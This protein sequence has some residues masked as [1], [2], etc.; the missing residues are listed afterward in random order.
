MGPI[1]YTV[2]VAD[3]FKA[4]L[5]GYTGGA[6]IRNDFQAQD[7]RRIAIQ[8][9]QQQQEAKLAMQQ[10]LYR[11]STNKAAT[12]ADYASTMT[13][14]PQ[15]SEQLKKSWDVLNDDQKQSKLSQGSQAYAAIKSGRPD[16]AEK[17]F[18]DRAAA[19]KNTGDERAAKEAETM[20]E[21]IR[22]HP[23]SA[24][25]SVALSLAA[26]MGPEKF[27]SSFASLGA[28]QR[29]EAEAPAD[30]AIKNATAGIKGAEAVNTP[31]KL[32]LDN[33][34]TQSQI[35]DRAA[36]QRI[37]ELNTQIGQANSETQRGQLILERDK[38]V[39]DQ[40]FKKADRGAKKADEGAA[41]QDALDSAEALV[42]Q[43]K[44]VQGHPGL[45]AGTGTMSGIRSF[46]NSTD[47][48]DFRKAVEGLKSP[49]FLNELGKLKA[50]GITLGQV[51]EAEGKKLEQRIANLDP[52][53]ST[54][55]FKNQVGVLLKDTEKFIEKI[56]AGGKLPI[57]GGAFLM[58]VPG[59]GDV[60]EGDINRMLTANPGST[61]EQAIQYL[62]SRAA[63][64]TGGAQGS[65]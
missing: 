41:A 4:A 57:S 47:A 39:A 45:N 11:L 59:V 30:L 44:G 1:D 33:A 48:N 36:G 64:N 24:G 52:D 26:Y 50:A 9:A 21:F 63:K 13:R 32:A 58:K 2:Q 53:Q 6:A 54:P 25:T 20:A 7:D 15:F 23:E 19:A 49:V 18:R 46:F 12:G 5:Q 65:Y 60:R 42:A 31:T 28:E 38:L 35:E 40:E 37:A 8:Q 10:D 14:Y 29:A 27:A 43:I 55:A 61:R 62:K 34:N 16:I 56:K 17:L 22:M 3:P 51:T